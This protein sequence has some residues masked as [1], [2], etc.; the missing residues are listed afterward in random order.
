MADDDVEDR[1][2]TERALAASRG[3]DDDLRFVG[4]GEEVMD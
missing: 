1:V 3:V 2:L 4:D